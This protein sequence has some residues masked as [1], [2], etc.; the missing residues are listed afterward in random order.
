MGHPI[1]P[2]DETAAY[3][4]AT[5]YLTALAA[6]ASRRAETDPRW[7]SI[8]DELVRRRT[9]LR[10]QHHHDIQAVLAIDAADLAA[11]LDPQ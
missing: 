3:D 1:P 5:R 4:R 9:A 7:A 11:Q 10:P 6:D 8:R 2:L